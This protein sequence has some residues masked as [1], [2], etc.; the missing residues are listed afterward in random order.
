MGFAPGKHAT[1]TWSHPCLLPEAGDADGSCRQ[2]D[3]LC[4]RGLTQGA[5]LPCAPWGCWGTTH[6]FEVLKANILKLNKKSGVS[7][8]LKF[9]ISCCSSI[10]ILGVLMIHTCVG[11]PSRL[12]SGS[13]IRPSTSLL[14]PVETE[15][16]ASQKWSPEANSGIRITISPIQ[17]RRE[18]LG[19]D[20]N[21]D[22][23]FLL[24]EHV[25]KLWSTSLRTSNMAS[26][27]QDQLTAGFAAGA[28][29]EA[30]NHM[31]EAM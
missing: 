3:L 8:G 30:L 1:C 15:A 20:W 28:A 16:I 25:A 14:P 29:V 23:M 13:P 27:R 5:V 31:C 2:I 18:D 12:R 19:G 6:R 4:H 24:L 26:A 7:I 21:P 10:R 17:L 11:R 22:T 9:L